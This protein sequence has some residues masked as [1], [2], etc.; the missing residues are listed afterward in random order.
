MISRSLHRRVAGIDHY[1]ALEIEHA[2][3]VTQRDVEQ[4]ADTRGQALEEPHVGAGRG[5]LDV[6]QA[7]TANLGQGDFDAA[8]V[9]DDSAV[10]HALV[11]AAQAFPVGDGAKDAGAE[12][13]V[14]LRLEG[15]VVDC[16]RLG[17]F[18]VRPAANLF[19]RGE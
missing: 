5:Q 17:H 6:A 3:E 2:F 4:V 8:L 14:A 16:F 18:A 19:R 1:V 13:S 10:L 12:E 7:L 15:A 11:F 9:A